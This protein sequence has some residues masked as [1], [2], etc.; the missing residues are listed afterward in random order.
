MTLLTVTLEQPAQVTQRVRNGNINHTEEFIPGGAVR[1]AFAAAWISRHGQPTPTNRRRSA[2]VELFEGGVRFGPLY[3]GQPP[4]PLSVYGHKYA[5]G[6]GCPR[7]EIDTALEPDP[8][9]SF[10]C[11]CGETFEQV[12]GLRASETPRVRRHTSAPI[13]GSGVALSGSLHSRDAIVAGS[14]LSGQ[15]LSEQADLIDELADLGPLQ[16]GGRRTTHGLARAAVTGSDN[17]PA[18]QRHPG[19]GIIIRLGSPAVLVDDEGRPA[20]APSPRELTAA[21]RVPAQVANVW[22][23]W[24]QLGGW[25][26]ASGLPKHSEVCVA[27]G[28]TYLVRCD[29][30]VPDDALAALARRGLGLRR[31]E[32]FGHLSGQPVLRRSRAEKEEERNAWARLVTSMASLRLNPALHS[33]IRAHLAGD[34]KAESR[35]RAHA[36]S[37]R[38]GLAEPQLDRLLKLPSETIVKILDEWKM[39]S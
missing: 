29:G 28:S 36:A 2:F 7:A 15:L 17:T 6:V 4:L 18:P 9:A 1:G 39:T 37:D 8:T 14:I 31:H 23:R 38:F 20:L 35:A 21:L 19:G 16:L 32:G 24:D 33:D 11:P 30:E 12:R 27:A 5:D 10:A 13:H 25:H 3:A 26:A 34:A 22:A